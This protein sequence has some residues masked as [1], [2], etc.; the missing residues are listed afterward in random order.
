MLIVIEIRPDSADHTYDGPGRLWRRRRRVNFNRLIKSPTRQSRYGDGATDATLDANTT[1]YEHVAAGKAHLGN[2]DVTDEEEPVNGKVWRWG[3][4]EPI[5][6]PQ[7]SSASNTQYYMV[8]DE[9]TIEKRSYQVGSV[10]AGDYN[11][12]SRYAEWQQVNGA[13]VPCC[14]S[15][16][17]IPSELFSAYDITL[18]AD[19][20]S[21]AATSHALQLA[22]TD[23]EYEGTRVKSPVLGRDL[24]PLGRGEAS[25]SPAISRQSSDKRKAGR[26]ASRWGW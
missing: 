2:I 24:N 3:A 17:A 8:N 20:A 23:L 22:A 12:D 19:R 7:R 4:G 13:A 15:A 18:D 1:N 10:T 9:R 11:D 26:E 14:M 21:S 5:E 25:Q 16:G 6:C